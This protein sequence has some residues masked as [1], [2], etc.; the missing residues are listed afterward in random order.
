MQVGA[1]E[2]LKE[3]EGAR[4]SATRENLEMIEWQGLRMT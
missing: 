4:K 3:E 2:G 1:D